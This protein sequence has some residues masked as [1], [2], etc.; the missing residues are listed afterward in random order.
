MSPQHHEAKQS[1]QPYGWSL[2]R[3]ITGSNFSQLAT[4]HQDYEHQDWMYLTQAC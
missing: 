1:C 2:Q 4:L 3:C